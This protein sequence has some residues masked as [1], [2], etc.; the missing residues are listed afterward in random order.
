MFFKKINQR[1]KVVFIIMLLLLL[2]IIFRVFYIQII[3]Y[4]KLKEYADDLWSRELPIEA[5]RGKILDRNGEVLADN[6]TTTSLVLI[7]NQIKNKE[8]V[9]KEDLAEAPATEEA[10]SAE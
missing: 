1:I 2:L 3:D 5:N 8:I 7:P 4:E 6:L 10:Q 9:I